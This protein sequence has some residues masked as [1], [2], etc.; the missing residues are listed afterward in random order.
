[1]NIFVKRLIKTLR[2]DIKYSMT[3]HHRAKF[4]LFILS[5]YFDLNRTNNTNVNV[6]S[7][8]RQLTNGFGRLAWIAH[9]KVLKN[10]IQPIVIHYFRLTL[11]RE[12]DK[13]KSRQQRKLQTRGLLIQQTS[14]IQIQPYGSNGWIELLQ[15]LY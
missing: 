11:K 8:I 1:M 5:S 14:Q 3:F 2:D 9:S 13:R 10:E 15:S 4:V 7:N 6:K 12:I